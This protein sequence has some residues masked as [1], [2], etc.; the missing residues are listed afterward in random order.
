MAKPAFDI[1]GVI[2]ECSC[3]YR[4]ARRP[5][6]TMHDVCYTL[7]TRWSKHVANLEHTFCTCILNTFASCLL[8]RVNGVLC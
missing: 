7:F 1:S 4:L 6:V 5:N 3:L 8:H 2:C